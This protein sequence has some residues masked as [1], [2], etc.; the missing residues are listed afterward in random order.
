M[1]KRYY[2]LG[3]L[4][5]I[6]IVV[7]VL[8][9]ATRNRTPKKPTG[10]STITVW[11]SFDNEEDFS[12]IFSQF[13]SENKN[14]DIKFV[15]KDPAKLEEESINAF[16]AGTGPDIWII[17]NNWLAKHHD[18][19]TALTEKK[20]DPKAKKTNAEI[21]QT[22]YLDAANQ[23]CI[24]GGQVYCLP[25]FMDSL[26]L[27]YNSELFSSK[28]SDYARA[29]QG[30]DITTV[31]QL[32]NG[33]PKTWE[34]L[35]QFIKYYGQGAIAMGGAKNIGHASDILTALMIQYGA[36]MTSDDKTAALFQTSTNK[37]S[38]V[39]YP[40]TKGLSLYT[41]F[42]TKN[43]P[44]YT[45]DESQN[46]YNAFTSGKIAMYLDWSRKAK[47]IKKDT[48]RTAEVAALPQIKDS[49]NP[50]DIANYQVLT[51]P[52]SSQNGDKAWALIQY[53]IDPQIQMKYISKTGLPQARK[54]KVQ[55]SN[56]FIDVQN[57]YASSWYNPEPTKVDQLFRDAA[58]AVLSGENPQTVLEGTAAQVT[59]LLK[60][61]PQ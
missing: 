54:D 11:D 35:T 46:D 30:Q 37:I 61:L 51:V 21:F 26:S 41:S 6:L 59:N 47:D 29:H 4:L 15:K 28:L 55:G 13:L 14:L 3:G 17:P 23:D 60:A 9:L 32:F 48:G 38:D 50:Q 44:N 43:D 7:L 18:K 5:L 40:G 25:L 24:I 42:A 52:K 12:D 19:L 31:R 27:F 2:I 36:Q 53:I 20:L 39:A 58:S 45:W 34:D 1:D 10:S 33:P 49:K 56:V 16:A 57:Q 8:F 22:T